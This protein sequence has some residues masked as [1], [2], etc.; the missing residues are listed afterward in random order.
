MLIKIM[1]GDQED[2]HKNHPKQLKIKK[3]KGQ[4]KSQH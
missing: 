3:K 1:F 2:D 4:N